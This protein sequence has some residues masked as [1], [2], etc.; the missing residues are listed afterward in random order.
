MAIRK[1][2]K[3]QGPSHIAPEGPVPRK[4]VFDISSASALCRISVVGLDENGNDLNFMNTVVIT[5]DAFDD[6]KVSF[7]RRYALM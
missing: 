3:S 6:L 1:R 2:R 7:D 5:R 4:V